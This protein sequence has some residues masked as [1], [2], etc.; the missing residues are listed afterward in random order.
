MPSPQWRYT[1]IM[2]HSEFYAKSVILN[3]LRGNNIAGFAAKKT[4]FFL[5]CNLGLPVQQCLSCVS[6][7][8]L[9]VSSFSFCYG[10][11]SSCGLFIP[12]KALRF[13]LPK[14]FNLTSEQP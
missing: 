4:S 5:R 3:F 2:R 1:I 8:V 13:C 9:E 14:K 6:L 12:L 11:I 10:G 7:H